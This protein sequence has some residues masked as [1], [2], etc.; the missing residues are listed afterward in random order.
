LVAL[1]RVE[2]AGGWK[3]AGKMPKLTNTLDNATTH[4]LRVFDA[5]P[6]YTAPRAAGVKS[7]R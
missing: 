6:W 2:V 3:T 7:S 4:A 1:S 5:A